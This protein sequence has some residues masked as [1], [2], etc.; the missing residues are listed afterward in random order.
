MTPSWQRL[1]WMLGLA[2]ASTSTLIVGFGH[3]ALAQ[4]QPDN[5]S[6]SG[7]ELGIINGTQITQI[8]GGTARGTNLFHSFQQF[9]V[10][11]GQGAFFTNPVGIEN[12]LARVTGS[13]LSD[14]QGILGVTGGNA[15]L[16][17][18]NPNGIIFGPDARLNLGGSF[19]A[20]TANAIALA[21][22]DIFSTN[23]GVPLPSQVLNVNPN[24]FFFNQI[25]AQPIVSQARLQV[26][27]GASLML[28]GGDVRQDG[29][30]LQAPGGRIELAGVAGV[31]NVTL[32][33]NGNTLSLNL[34]DGVARADVSLTNR[35]I[36]N[37][38]ATGGGSIATFL[39]E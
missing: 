10:S 5:T 17:L 9:N 2:S 30:L 16:F 18:I 23:L 12:I 4:I 29:G 25:A 22:G 19:V 8:T 24:A 33:T 35:A 1:C 32:N 7:I 6:N 14:I 27:P 28:V 15:N 11:A 26:L 13:N 34:P 20:T 36:V 21:N 38:A 39:R 3:C 31:G 37:V